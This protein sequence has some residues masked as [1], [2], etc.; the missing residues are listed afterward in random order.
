[1][2]SNVDDPIVAKWIEESLGIEAI[3]FIEERPR[4]KFVI[5]PERAS[6]NQ[7]RVKKFQTEKWDGMEKFLS[8]YNRADDIQKIA[9]HQAHPFFSAQKRH[10]NK[11]V[12]ERKRSNVNP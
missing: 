12:P 10:E 9:I 3:D 7:F 1:M 11:L 2:L 5:Y 4:F 8:D 6:D